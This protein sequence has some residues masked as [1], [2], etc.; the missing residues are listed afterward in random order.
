MYLLV[1][2]T[3]HSYPFKGGGRAKA[4]YSA[5]NNKIYRKIKFGG[6]NV[7]SNGEMRQILKKMDFDN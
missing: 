5:M 1:C 3:S 2:L 7:K 6:W 4:P